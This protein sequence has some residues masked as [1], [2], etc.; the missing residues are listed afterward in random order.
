M[1]KENIR[2]IKILKFDNKVLK[3]SLKKIQ[4]IGINSF[5]TEADII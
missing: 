2:K 3:P 1:N 4:N 5:M